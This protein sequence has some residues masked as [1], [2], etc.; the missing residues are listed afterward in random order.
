[1]CAGC[2][3]YKNQ[4]CSH[5]DSWCHAVMST[6]LLR[7][8]ISAW[9]SAFCTNYRKQI[10]N[11]EI[12]ARLTTSPASPGWRYCFLLPNRHRKHNGEQET[13]RMWSYPRARPFKTG[14]SYLQFQSRNLRIATGWRHCTGLLKRIE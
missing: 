11:S 2:K 9:P 10:G 8:N 3:C 13:E 5:L 12:E 1:S 7:H 4:Y 14:C 6:L